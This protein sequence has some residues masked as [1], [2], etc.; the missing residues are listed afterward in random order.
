[1][2]LILEKKFAEYL[3]NQL[4]NKYIVTLDINKFKALNNI[5]GYDF[6][7][8][9]LKTMGDKLTKVLPENSVTSRIS[10]DVFATIFSYGKDINVLLDKMISTISTMK[11][12]NIDIHV[13]LSVGVYKVRDDDKDINKVLDKAYMARAE[14]KGLYNQAYYIFDNKLESQLV[15][16]QKIESAMDK[17]LENKEF[18]VVYQPKM[19]AQTETISGA[20]ALVRWQKDGEIVSPGKF[21]SLFEKNKFIIKLDLY[22]F[23]Q[24]CEDIATWKEKFGFQPVVS[25]NVSKEHF[26]NEKFIDEYVEITEKYNLDRSKIDLEITESATMDDNINILK[27]L[28]YIKENGFMISID[29]F[30]TGYSSLS[31]LQ[32]M[33]IDVIKID[34]VFVDKAD[35]SSN[36]NIINYIMY[37]AKRLEV[38]T[39]VEGVETKEQVDYIRKLNCDV[40]QGYYYSKPISKEEFEEYV[41][42]I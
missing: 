21:I 2:K 4:D 12:S 31:M 18:K 3:Q 1:M 38:K 33:P 30:G 37:L 15:E 39:I 42:N 29:D 36:E 20:E 28:N 14:I 27:I 22:V 35:L 34:K 40:I 11:I 26:V 7:N 17:A 32:N 16:E 19:Y 9:I 5:Y 41:K 23:K 8:T 6:C 13:N 10:N 24:A 25:I